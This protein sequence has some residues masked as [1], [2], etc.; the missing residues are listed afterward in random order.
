LQETKS[1]EYSDHNKKNAAYELLI[2]ELKEIDPV[3]N[4]D[5]IKKLILPVPA[6]ETKLK[7]N[8]RIEEIWSWADNITSP[9]CGTSMICYFWRI[10]K[11]HKEM[12]A[13]LIQYMMIN[14][15]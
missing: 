11:P 3:V 6:F 10:K 15:T 14:A 7:R 12:S 13:V 8:K 1:K 5:Y 2:N 9:I 4:K